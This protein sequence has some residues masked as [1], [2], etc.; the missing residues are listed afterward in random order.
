MSETPAERICAGCKKPFSRKDPRGVY[1]SRTCAVR[2]SNRR[3]PRRKRKA[4][5]ACALTQCETGVR[6]P[7]KYCSK[8]HYVQDR[9]ETYVSEWLSGRRLVG[10]LLR[11]GNAIREYLYKAQE[12]TCALCPCSREWNGKPLNFILD[13]IDGN[14]LDSSRENLRL[15]CPNCDFQLPTSKGKNRGNGRAKRRERYALG[16]ST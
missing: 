16:L 4:D 5:A 15:L 1:C 9:N 2:V 12:N 11:E 7:S 14:S 13:H 8:A 3:E 10:D 6:H